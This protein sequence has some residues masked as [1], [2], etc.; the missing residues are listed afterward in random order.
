M[1]EALTI[2]RQIAEALE[3][4][5]GPGSRYADEPAVLGGRRRLFLF[6]AHRQSLHVRLGEQQVW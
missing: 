3:A 4:A 5:H 2:A 6:E 1:N